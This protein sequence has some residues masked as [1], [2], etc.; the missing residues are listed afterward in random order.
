MRTIGLSRLMIDVTSPIATL[1]LYLR[2]IRCRLG[3]HNYEIVGISFYAGSAPD[4]MTL[5]CRACRRK[6]TRPR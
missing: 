5:E 4:R 1:A 6:V 2:R 3:V